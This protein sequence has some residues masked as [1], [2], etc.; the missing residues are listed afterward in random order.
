MRQSHPRRTDRQGL[1]VWRIRAL[2]E[3]GANDLLRSGARVTSDHAEFESAL[4]T[5]P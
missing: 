1:T 4:P 3:L 2:S 5:R